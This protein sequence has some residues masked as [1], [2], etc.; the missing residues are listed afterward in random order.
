MLLF[1]SIEIYAIEKPKNH[2]NHYAT[3]I[4][5]VPE[6]ASIDSVRLFLY[7]EET[8]SEL[9]QNITGLIS[10]TS[11]VENGRYSFKIP[12]NDK[13]LYFSLYNIEGTWPESKHRLLN[14]HLVEK[15]DYVV[16]NHLGRKITFSGEGSAKHNL[17]IL[18]SNN[19]GFVYQ[20][21]D[22][23]L[24]TKMVGSRGLVAQNKFRFEDTFSKIS[25]LL[26]L[27]EK[28]RPKLSEK[29]YQV[30][31][32]EIIGNSQYPLMRVIR[33][34]N[35]GIFK[36]EQFEK[37]AM[38]SYF[39]KNEKKL[40]ISIFPDS[41][42]ASSINYVKYCF[43]RL[44][45]QHALINDSS[46]LVTYIIKST[47]KGELRDKLLIS[48]IGL[49]FKRFGKSLPSALENMHSTTMKHKL[50]VFYNN[51]KKGAMLP[52]DLVL[53]NE[54]NEKVNLSIYKGKV[55]FLDFWYIGCIP[56]A[57]Y[58]K[59]TVSVA[60]KSFSNSE[61]VFFITIC[62]EKDYNKWITA[63]KSDVYTSK[64]AVNLFTGGMERNHPVLTYFNIVSAPTPILIDKNFKIFSRDEIYLGRG[65]NPSSLVNAIQSCI[66]Y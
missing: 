12:V 24:Y 58:Y 40:F 63:L 1:Q 49:S 13:L 28:N 20:F 32:C 31:H 43:E 57:N 2:A 59:S 9:S 53:Y 10:V 60:K 26:K 17:H 23:E 44:K 66:E 54:N 29:S 30:L 35:G 61:N 45:L 46:D 51:Q 16:I 64:S 18:F 56:C 21:D 33:N 11:K 8:A 25:R 39:M 42:T 14:F 22:R 5:L 37:D 7:D 6:S 27:L 4:G 62:T 36:I 34:F 52:S 38:K 19:D 65:G 15:G 55:I 50:Q 47:S 3:I 41:I 48:A